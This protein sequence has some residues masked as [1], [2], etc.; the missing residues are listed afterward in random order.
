MVLGIRP[1]RHAEQAAAHRGTLPV[2]QPATSKLLPA[3]A[4]L[5]PPRTPICN[6]IC[7]RAGTKPGIGQPFPYNHAAPAHIGCI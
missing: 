6:P 5:S 4:S 1:Q 7:S 2:Q 3:G